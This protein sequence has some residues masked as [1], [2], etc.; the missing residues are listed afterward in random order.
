MYFFLSHD[1]SLLFGGVLILSGYLGEKY[2]QNK[3]ISLFASLVFE[4][5]YS[6]IE[7]DSASSTE[8][9]AILSSLSQLPI[10]QWIAVSGSVNQKGAA[11]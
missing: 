3:M 11:R 8:L 1:A 4:Q 9:Y 10:K 6:E 7:G 2:G 5:S